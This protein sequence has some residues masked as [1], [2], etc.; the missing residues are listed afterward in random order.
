M[1]IDYVYQNYTMMIFGGES[2]DSLSG[3]IQ[4][5]SGSL[6]SYISGLDV[7]K[8]KTV[9]LKAATVAFE[10]ALTLG[11]TFAISKLLEAFDKFAHAEEQ[12]VEQEKKFRQETLDSVR[13]YNDEI[14]E[15]QALSNS[16]VELVSTTSDLTNEKE[17]L[18]EIQDKINKGIEDQ[19]DKV[20]LL[21]KSLSEN[22]ELT[23]KQ[24]LE[25]AQNVISQNQAMYESIIEGENASYAAMQTYGDKDVA[26]AISEIEFATGQ[27]ISGTLSEQSKQLEEILKLYHDID[28][29]SKQYY[30][31]VEKGKQAIDAQLA[32][33]NEIKLIRH[34]YPGVFYRF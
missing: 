12:A 27:R 17:K 7:A 18:L 34:Q 6:R 15:S 8:L 19:T 29:Y 4:R 26:K 28:G 23:S 30:N 33:W 10:A 24:R 14:K 5:A 3:A 13:A 25:E 20:D 16:Y 21:N 11:L 31:D 22:I 1:S 2:I 9:A 32:D